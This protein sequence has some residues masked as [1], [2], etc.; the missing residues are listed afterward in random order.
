MDV[1]LAL[2]ILSI[3]NVWNFQCNLKSDDETGFIFHYGLVI[4]S[5]TLEEPVLVNILIETGYR[6]EKK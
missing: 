2:S 3:W 6:S 1:E 5:V 4:A